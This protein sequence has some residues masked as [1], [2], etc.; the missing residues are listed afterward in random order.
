MVTSVCGA[1]S[2]SSSSYG[3]SRSSRSSSS[4][5]GAIAAQR[6]SRDREGIGGRGDVVHAEHRRAALEGEHVRR[7]G[8]SDALVWVLAADQLP[9]EPLARRADQHAEAEV[10]ELVE[11]AE[12][13]E[14]VG[15][16]LAEADAG[17]E[18]DALGGDPLARRERGALGEE[19]LDVG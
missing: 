12:K 7:D 15:D 1:S 3:S 16:R 13:L 6:S 19:R 8:C 11:A 18:Q 10:E 9:Q 2:P 17:V 4:R 5:S 14:V